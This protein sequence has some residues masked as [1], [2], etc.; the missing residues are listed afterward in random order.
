MSEFS[1]I[2][3][4]WLTWHYQARTRNIAK[5]LN[6]PVYEYFKN[7]NLFSRHFLSSLWTL[8]VLLTKRPN[9]IIIQCS[10]MLLLIVAIYKALRFNKVILIVDCHTKALRRKAKGLLN[11]VFWPLKKF[12]FKF[13]DLSIVSN[14]GLL[15]ELKI[16]HTNYLILPDKIPENKIKVAKPYSGKYCVYISS[17]AVDEPFKEILEVSE[18]LKNEFK[19]FWTGKYPDIVN[20]IKQQYSNIEFT[21]YLTFDHYYNLIGNADCLMALTTEEDCLQSGAYE[22][23]SLGVPFII[24]NTRALREYFQ[25]AAV[26]TNHSPGEITK[27]IK[28]SFDNSAKLI[29]EMKKIK[30]IRSQEFN[31]SLNHI[32]NLLNKSI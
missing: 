3:K 13:A 18:L 12:S 4:I 14:R 7:D 16:L 9:K 32:S 5:A 28:Y 21:G 1:K 24:S 6:I 27:A 23:L 11:Y 8:K 25:G 31:L 26:Y 17:F 2:D 15:K 22:A 29:S 19:L 10:F 30:E 20:D